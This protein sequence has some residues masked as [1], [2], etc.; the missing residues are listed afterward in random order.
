MHIVKRITALCL[1]LL[2]LMMT[3]AQADVPFLVHSNGWD[4]NSTPVE[5]LIKADVDTHMPF[6]DD[7]LAML[8]PITDM[9][10]LRLVTGADEGLVSI[11]IADY[12]VLSLQYRGNAVQLSSMPEVTYTAESDTMSML[13]G[14]DVSV[15]G[16]FEALG[17]ARD[18]ETLITDGAALLDKLP[19]ML[20]DY[21]KRSKNTTNIS[22]YGRA[23]YRYDYTIAASKAD[24]LKSI[25]LSA[26]PD[27]WL[28]EII[29]GLT[30]SGK[31]TL[32]MYY[33]Q[34]DVLLRAEYNGGCGPEGDLRTVKLVY[35]QRHDEEAD[36]D[37][38]EL[39]SPAK[40][41]KNKNNLTFERAVETNNK[42]QRVVQGTY[43][44]TAT[45]DNVTSIRKGDFDLVNAF[46][47]TA[48]VIT[49]SVTFQ[50]KLDGAE[51]Y[52][53][54]TLAPELTISG[55][56]DAP[57]I[58]GTLTVTEKYADKTTEH[59]V[60]SIDLKRAE[61]LAWAERA[62]TIDLSALDADDLASAQQKAA[63]SIATA[64]VHPLVVMMGADAEWFFR[65]LPEDAVQNIID[66]AE[67]SV[68]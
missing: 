65:E 25:L 28:Q 18:A 5:V 40:K 34:G 59:A 60:L 21:G 46:N 49:G 1:S 63:A 31:Q 32:R 44:Y 58:A 8:T 64:I 27:G 29:S 53:A 22:G 43:T 62:E 12:D 36:K 17:L 56:V 2:L 42:G 61:S 10:S 3:I 16:G 30:F 47:D 15:G 67:L 4:M 11:A 51:K 20:Q 48:D 39:T 52:S 24:E 55:S 41:G 54:L 14:A 57:V 7:R 50:N 45:L 26:C 38:I 6:D 19:D 37:Y 13:L 23:A 68:N 9:M 66:A 35:K 33:T